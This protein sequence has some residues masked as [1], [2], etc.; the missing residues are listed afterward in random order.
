MRLVTLATALGLIATPALAAS[1]IEGVWRT[2]A[3]GGLIQI[4]ACGEA[5]CGK[6]VGSDQLGGDP[7]VLDVHNKDAALRTRPLKG[8]Q[9]LSGFAGGPP[10]WKGGSIYNPDD[11]GTYHGSIKLDGPDTLKLTGCVVAPFCRTETWRR[12]K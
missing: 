4:S 2:A 1:P 3:H 12:A 8:L 5:F 6:I 11:G 9:I 10:E 7:N